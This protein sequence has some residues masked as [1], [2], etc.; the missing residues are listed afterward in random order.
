MSSCVPQG[1]LFC[2]LDFS[3]INASARES[4]ISSF[5]DDTALV[6]SLNKTIEIEM[7]RMTF[8]SCVIGTR[9]K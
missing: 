9:F 4:K 6:A 1:P 5:A 2:L 8:D 3:T 7:F